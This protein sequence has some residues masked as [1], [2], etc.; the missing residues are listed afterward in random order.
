[1]GMVCLI[2]TS[3]CVVDMVTLDLLNIASAYFNMT[4]LNVNLNKVNSSW[5]W[6]TIE[7]KT[8]QHI[9][10]CESQATDSHATTLRISVTWETIHKKRY[11]LSSPSVDTFSMTLFCRTHGLLS[12]K[13]S[14][15]SPVG[16]TKNVQYLSD[17][18]V[19]AL[20][21]SH[22]SPLG[23]TVNVQ[24]VRPMGCCSLKTSHCSPLG[25]TVSFH[26]VRPMDWL[27]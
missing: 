18:W 6:W 23:L 22:C 25:L 8:S 21:T 13:T 20:K 17:P 3:G 16:L 4:S 24:F 2:V 26:F 27:V 14:H 9:A 1:M 12:S 10:V 19:A 15:Y 11:I 7:Y 5:R